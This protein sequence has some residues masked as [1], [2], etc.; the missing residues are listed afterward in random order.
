MRLERTLKSEVVLEGVGIHSGRLITLRLLPALPGYGLVFVRTDLP[1]CPEI[2][3]HYSNIVNT[4]MATTLGCGRAHVGT[5]EHLMAALHCLS[6]DNLRIELNGPEVPIMDGSSAPFFEA[7]GRVGCA[8]QLQHRSYAVLK[9]RIEVKLDGKW[10]LAEP[11]HHFEIF[12]SIEWDHPSIG[13]QEYHYREGASSPED[14]M[15]ARTFGFLWEVENLKRMGL[16]RG[17]SLDNAVVLDQARVLNPDGLRS[18]DEFVKH[19]VLDALGDF[20]LAGLPICASFRLHRAGH[21]LH[22]QVLTEI[23]KSPHHYE[24]VEGNRFPGLSESEALAE[25]M[26]AEGLATG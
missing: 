21:D 1:G 12:G 13:Y 19:K 6:I 20:K 17:G 3:A 25:A 9:K 16:A 8:Q 26:M 7:M 5:V 18:P 24:I 23:F 10:A 4:Q 15:P 11:S 14:L 22:K 2:A